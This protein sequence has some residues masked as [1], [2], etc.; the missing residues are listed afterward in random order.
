MAKARRLIA[1][2]AYDPA[3]LKMLGEVFDDAWASVSQNYKSSLAVEAAR[4]KLANI[5]LSLAADGERNP[6]QL[7]DGAVRAFCVDES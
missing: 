3:T 7:K 5:V 4:L 1:G 2:A 6:D